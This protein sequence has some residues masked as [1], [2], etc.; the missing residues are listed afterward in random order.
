MAQ[1]H[2]LEWRLQTGQI[3]LLVIP[4]YWTLWVQSLWPVL[5]T[6]VRKHQVK[7]NKW[8]W[9]F[10]HIIDT[11]EMK[12][13]YFNAIINTYSWLHWKM[14]FF[15]KLFICI[16]A[17]NNYLELFRI[18]FTC[19]FRQTQIVMCHLWRVEKW[20]LIL[21]CFHLY[22]NLLPGRST[23]YW[24]KYYTKHLHWAYEPKYHASETRAGLF[25]PV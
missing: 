12:L 6:Y 1:I 8:I 15:I 22:C 24:L 5:H 19:R 20:I 17:L 7:W 18:R 2:T 25:L 10:I 21:I 9:M 13:K 14:F 4:F 16:F 3:T 23:E 11:L